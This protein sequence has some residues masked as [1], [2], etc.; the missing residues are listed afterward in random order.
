MRLAICD[1]DVGLVNRL[2]PL[3]YQ[4]ANDNRFEMVID[5]FYSG[6]ALLESKTTYDMI[7]LD[8]KMGGMNGMDV[9]RKLRERNINC[10]IVFM[11]N[12]PHF[13]YEAFEVNTFRFCEKPFEQ[14]RIY[15]VLDDY[16]A[17]YG[18]DYPILLKYERETIQ[19]HTG[20]IV[21]IE[22]MRKQ[23]IISRPKDK[24]RIAK[25]LAIITPLL[26]KNH[27]FRVNR[28]FIINFNY[29]A[30]YN[31]EYVYMKNGDKVPQSR[32][33]LADFKAS[34]LAYVDARHPKRREHQPI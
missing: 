1:D 7:F 19:I 16:F 22:A 29:I 2:K 24:I 4:Y 15:E 9:A 20:E 6:E 33:Y 3:V 5:E 17:M 12:Y 21:C 32:K 18:N 13:V 11:T 25:H 23:S 14:V 27:F 30:K 31:N 8:Y 34:Y 26:P 10:T 28:S